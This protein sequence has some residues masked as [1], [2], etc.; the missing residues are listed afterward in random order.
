MF[1]LIS[2]LT[3]V[4]F[5]KILTLLPSAMTD[6]VSS[7][8]RDPVSTCTSLAV[9]PYDDCAVSDFHRPERR[10]KFADF[11]VVIGQNWRELGVAAVVW[12]AV[13]IIII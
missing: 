8:D 1:I 2:T 10:F 3:S 11:D 9:V 12:D 7:L 6:D 4:C 13:R 5:V